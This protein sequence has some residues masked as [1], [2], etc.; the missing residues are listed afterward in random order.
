MAL[1]SMSTMLNRKTA[2][3]PYNLLDD[4]VGQHMTESFLQVPADLTVRE[5]IDANPSMFAN[6]D[7]NRTVFLTDEEGLLFGAISLREMRRHN[8]DTALTNISGPVRYFARAEDTAEKCAKLMHKKGLSD[9]PI[10]RSGKLVG[11][12]T[13]DEAAIISP[14]KSRKNSRGTS[15]PFLSFFGLSR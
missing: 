12:L 7:E 15:R 3:N 5:A 8:D 11:V 2:F 10:V 14:R 13:A 9:L 1:N 6:A 4:T